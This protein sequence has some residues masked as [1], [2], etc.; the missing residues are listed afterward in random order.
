M[1][2]GILAGICAYLYRHVSAK[3]AINISATTTEVLMV[4]FI[5]AALLLLPIIN[6]SSLPTIL[7]QHFTIVLTFSF[8]S[9]VI[10]IFFM[11]YAVNHIGAVHVSIISATVFPFTWFGDF[12]LH[13]LH[14][15]NDIKVS[16]FFI[17]SISLIVIIFPY[18]YKNQFKINPHRK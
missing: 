8:L 11:Q 2:L 16:D 17:S 12:I 9:L 13:Y 6:F 3:F 10:P 15:N 5:P 4:R 1:L 14:H 18:L 7:E